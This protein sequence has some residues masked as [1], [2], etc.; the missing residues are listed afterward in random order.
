TATSLSTPSGSLDLHAS[1]GQ[2]A[3]AKCGLLEQFKSQAAECSEE[4]IISDAEGVVRYHDQGH[5]GDRPEISRN[6]LTELLLSGV[7]EDLIRWETKVLSVDSSASSPGKGKRWNITSSRKANSTSSTSN[8][9]AQEKEKEEIDDFD[10]VIGADGAWSKARA[11]LPAT[12]SPFYSGVSAITLTLP[13]LSTHPTL[14]RLLGGG[15]FWACAPRRTL[16]AHNGSLDTARIYLMLASPSETHLHSNQLTSLTGP[17]MARRLLEP[18]NAD[19]RLELEPE[20]GLELFQSFSREVKD[21]ITAA[22][23]SNPA[24]DVVD[25]K[26]LYMLPPT[27]N[28]WT[29]T[30]GLTLVGDAAHL[31]TPF[32]GEG[33][34]CAMLD[35]LE[36]SKAIIASH[37]HGGDLD[38]GVEGFER[39]M[40][41]RNRAIAEDTHGNLKLIF[42]DERAPEGIVRDFESHGGVVKLMGMG[43]GFLRGK[44]SEF[45]GYD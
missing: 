11:S 43:F 31:M 42:H 41:R 44:V 20:P 12:A 14:S 35:A 8:T 37:A 15:T 22:C 34:N 38:K 13:N 18:P 32:A 24:T 30:P 26:P 40:W 16:M 3:L 23:L 4:M 19:S 9:E 5:G 21:L 2:L 33:V 45:L 25:A 28:T 36:L 1:S 17:E 6:A 29:H 7:P 10:L 39:R 27:H